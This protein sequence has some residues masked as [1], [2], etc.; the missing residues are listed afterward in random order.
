MTV[1]NFLYKTLKA[2]TTDIKLE[3]N[4]QGTTIATGS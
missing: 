3:L 1:V 2:Y 4:R